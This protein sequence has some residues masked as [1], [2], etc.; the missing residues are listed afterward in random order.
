M[1]YLGCCKTCIWAAKNLRPILLVATNEEG[2]RPDTIRPALESV[3]ILLAGE[4]KR[5]KSGRRQHCLTRRGE[6][7]AVQRG[8]LR[9]SPAVDEEA[10]ADWFGPGCSLLFMREAMAAVAGGSLGPFRL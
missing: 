9:T 1:E 4:K 6:G 10:A 5:G 2:L 8:W 3:L 7:E